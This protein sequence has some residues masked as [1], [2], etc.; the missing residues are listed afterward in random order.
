[1]VANEVEAPVMILMYGAYG[2]L[3]IVESTLKTATSELNNQLKIFN[4]ILKNKQF[5]VGDKVTLAD[6]YLATTLVT[7]YR[8][9]FEEK[10]RK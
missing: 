10:A 9:Q 6:L 1:M 5:L 7:L 2:Y 8:F 4:D 3:D